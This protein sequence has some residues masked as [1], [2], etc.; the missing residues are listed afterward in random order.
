MK[1]VLGCDHGGFE[2]KEVIK[3][4]LIN[5]GY[6]ITD[7]GAYN[8]DSVDYPDFGER[9]ARMVADNEADRGI[10][11]CGT[12]IGISIAANKVK[13]IRCALCTNEYMAKMSRMHNNANMLALGARVLGN[14]L[15]V[16]IVDVWLSTEFEGGRHE[17]RVKKITD[18]EKLR[19]EE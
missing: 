16:D 11:I 17:N 7:I 15:S 3:K 18:I 10:I 1:I 4:H 19:V 13:G 14:G 5:C 12:G 9:A 2:L 8:T 6:D